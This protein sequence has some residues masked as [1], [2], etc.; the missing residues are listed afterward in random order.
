MS[1]DAKLDLLKGADQIS[2][3]MFG[4]KEERRQVYHLADHHCLPVIKMG[5]KLY[6]RRSS[7]VQWLADREGKASRDP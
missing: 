6:A 4:T 5:K 1:G 3:F 2:D 7:L